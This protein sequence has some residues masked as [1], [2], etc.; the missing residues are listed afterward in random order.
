MSGIKIRPLEQ[1]DFGLG[2]EETLSCP[3]IDENEVDKLYHQLTDEPERAITLVAIN[4]E[5]RVVGT[6]TGIFIRHIAN[7]GGLSML[8]EDV[9][10]HDDYRRR[11]IGRKLVTTLVRS[12]KD[13]GCDWVTLSCHERLIGF[14]EKMRIG[15]GLQG[16]TMALD[17]E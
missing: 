17:L 1:E 4:S 16:R 6:A 14:F 13:K 8:I 11:G 7:N 9:A 2:L 12:A 3:P 15:F 10:V 5:G